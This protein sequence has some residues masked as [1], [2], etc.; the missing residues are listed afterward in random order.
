LELG[1]IVIESLKITDTDIPFVTL[2]LL[3][4]TVYFWKAT[5]V[6]KKFQWFLS[7][8]KQHSLTATELLTILPGLITCH[9]LI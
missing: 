9:F 6:L 4:F 5:E 7:N 8:P 3:D 2:V 1:S